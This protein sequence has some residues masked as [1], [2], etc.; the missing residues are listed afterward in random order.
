MCS[1]FLSYLI[2]LLILVLTRS[3]ITEAYRSAFA[4][5]GQ[6]QFAEH[7][8]TRT[9]YL[10]S[11]S[12]ACRRKFKDWR[13][14]EEVPKDEFTLKAKGKGKQ[15]EEGGRSDTGTKNRKTSTSTRRR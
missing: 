14:S 1:R 7:S 3:P 5:A 10:E 15:K 13:S 12:N 2:H 8:V 9:E 4:F 6:A 11:G